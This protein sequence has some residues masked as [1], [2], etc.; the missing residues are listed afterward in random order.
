MAGPS[1]SSAPAV[2]VEHI[3]KAFGATVAVDDVSFVVPRG[4][5]HALLGENG[6]GKSTIV[7]LLA[8]LLPPD[9]GPFSIEGQPARLSNPRV[10]HA[11]GIQTAF[12]E[13]SLV[14]DLTVLDNILIPYGPTGA[15]GM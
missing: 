10:S 1:A 9:Q 4:S 2:S 5:V 8:G 11:K 15:L 14:K 13:M 7:K 3:R 6:A 12:Q